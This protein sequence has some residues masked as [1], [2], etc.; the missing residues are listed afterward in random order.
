MGVVIEFLVLL[1]LVVAFGFIISLFF[2]KKK[3]DVKVEVIKE[4]KKDAVIVEID[5]VK[6][7]LHY[8]DT[9]ASAMSDIVGWAHNL[10]TDAKFPLF[11]GEKLEDTVRRK[12]TDPFIK[13]CHKAF[14]DY[15]KNIERR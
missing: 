8:A 4:K 10:E 3:N 1:S 7:E 5:G 9:W 11:A 15:Q 13:E 2:E 14:Y 6:Y 12:G